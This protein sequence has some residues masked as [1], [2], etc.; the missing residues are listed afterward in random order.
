MQATTLF[1]RA[2]GNKSEVGNDWMPATGGRPLVLV[3]QL[4]K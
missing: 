1:N 2:T 4:E 3:L